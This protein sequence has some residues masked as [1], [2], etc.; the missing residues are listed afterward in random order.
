MQTTER[1]LLTLPVSDPLQSTPVDSLSL[2][3]PEAKLLLIPAIE[4]TVGTP[5]EGDIP[6][7]KWVCT[8]SS[9]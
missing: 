9:Q 6:G 1:Q 7:L 3:T 2:S 8:R 5:I 4:L